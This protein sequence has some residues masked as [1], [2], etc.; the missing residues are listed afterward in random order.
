MYIHSVNFKIKLKNYKYC[1]LKAILSPCLKATFLVAAMESSSKEEKMNKKLQLPGTLDEL[2]HSSL[3]QRAS[4]VLVDSTSQ[5]LTR[6]VAAVI[7]YNESYRKSLDEMMI[8]MEESIQMS[9]SAEYQKQIWDVIVATRSELDNNKAALRDVES[10]MDYVIKL[11]NDVAETSFLAN[12]EY[13]S[14]AMCERLHAA[15]QVLSSEKEK[16]KRVEKEYLKLQKN[17]VLNYKKECENDNKSD[18]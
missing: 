11:A 3:I 12:A 9:N 18:S 2:T 10:F 13:V 16:T 7:D 17:F 15:E 6:T 14:T 1:Q 8:L 5:L 4:T